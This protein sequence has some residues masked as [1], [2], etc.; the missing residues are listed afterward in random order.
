M[1]AERLLTD[2]VLQLLGRLFNAACAALGTRLV[3]TTTY[4]S[5]TNGQTKRY[6]M[7]IVSRLCH[8]IGKHHKKWDTFVQ[9]MTYVYIAQTPST[10]DANPFNPVLTR[11]PPATF[12]LPRPSAILSTKKA[13]LTSQKLCPV[14]LDRT[15]LF[16]AKSTEATLKAQRR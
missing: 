11:Q 5:K 15:P 7:T 14:L 1:H 6:D 9:L 12:G 4:H 3:T 2:S 10:T 16:P 8:Y 13:L